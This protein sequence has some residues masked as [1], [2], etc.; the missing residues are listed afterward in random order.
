MKKTLTRLSSKLAVVGLIISAVATSIAASSAPTL[1]VGLPSGGIINSIALQSDGKIVIGGSFATYNDL[2]R[3]H[4]ARLNADGSLDLTFGRLGVLYSS[5]GGSTNDVNVVAIQNVNGQEKILIGESQQSS[6]I[7]GVA[8]NGLTRVNPDGTVDTAFNNAV[9]AMDGKVTGI[10]VLS[11]GKIFVSGTFNT[12]SSVARS[13]I[14]IFNADGSLDQSFN[15]S[16]NSSNVQWA[17]PVS[18]VAANY[19]TSP[20]YIYGNPLIVASGGYYKLTSFDGSSNSIVNYLS[21]FTTAIPTSDNG[22]LLGG[23]MTNVN[24]S[25]GNKCLVKYSS[26]GTFDNTFNPS[27][28]TTCGNSGV[29]AMM[30]Q[31]GGYVIG[32]DYNGGSKISRIDSAGTTISTLATLNTNIQLNALAT[33]TVGSQSYILVGGYFT[34]VNGTAKIGLARIDSNTGVLDPT[35]P[36]DNAPVATT[37][38]TTA[39]APGSS[40]SAGGSNN[41]GNGS[42]GGSSSSGGSAVTTTAVAPTIPADS[43]LPVVTPAAPVT[44][45]VADIAPSTAT[46]TATANVTSFVAGNEPVQPI[47]GGTNTAFISTTEATNGVQVSSNAFSST[48]RVNGYLQTPDGKY[49]DLGRNTPTGNHFKFTPMKF[50]KP[51][52]FKVIATTVATGATARTTASTSVS[53]STGA[54]TPAFGPKNVIAVI[55]VLPRNE[56]AS[57]AATAVSDAYSLSGTHGST[58]FVDGSQL[59]VSKSGAITPKLF[60][61]FK[62]FVIGTLQATYSVNMK[63]QTFSCSYAKF[64]NAKATPKATKSVNN[65]F[66]KSYIASNKACVLPKATMTAALTSQV[67]IVVKLRFGRL[68]PTTAKAVNPDTKAPIKPVTRTMTLIFGKIS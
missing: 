10:Q 42:G 59:V 16:I 27:V 11:N 40:G 64:G 43:A 54:V 26:A 20:H 52:R 63:T 13:G 57:I 21:K 55:N 4:L 22:A 48:E 61:A 50:M 49:Y 34:Q 33:Q 66:P 3:Q 1:A 19:P 65:W 8:V 36:A 67:K 37:T 25:T 32:G 14:A 7:D 23:T 31:A 60:T 12:I 41:S 44:P 30:E 68:W 29:T 46:A 15:A 38:T 17:Y 56:P 5:T 6:F 53:T 47:A 9:G 28:I 18:A 35:F 51:G 24:N 39:P 45:E 62:G 2:R 58:T